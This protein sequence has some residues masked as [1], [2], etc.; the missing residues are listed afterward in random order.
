VPVFN[1]VKMEPWEEHAMNMEATVRFNGSLDTL[2]I[3]S[4]QILKGWGASAYRPIYTFLPQDKQQEANIEII[5]TVANSSDVSNIRV[6]NTALTD[7]FSNKPLVIAGDIRSSSLIERAGN[8]ILV[9]IGEIIG[10]QEEMYQEKPRQLPVELD[11]PH[12]LERKIV[13]KIPYGYRVKNPGD[14]NFDITHKRGQQV[15]MGFESS[16]SIEGDLLTVIIRESYRE[17]Q[18]PLSAFEDFKNVINAA[19]DFNKVVLVLEKE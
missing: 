16:Y 11:F 12:M 3:S 15:T 9:K 5:R 10:P 18:Y 6:E 4:R 8:K 17:M 7:Y 2:Y 14:L 13:F 19:A 1:E